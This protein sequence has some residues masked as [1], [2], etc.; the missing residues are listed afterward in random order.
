MFFRNAHK[1]R[2][3]QDRTENTS[4]CPFCT[5]KSVGSAITQNGT[6]GSDLA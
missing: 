1:N 4:K 5:D 3:V 6:D 2:F